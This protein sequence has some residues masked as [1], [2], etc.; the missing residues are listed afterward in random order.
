[1][2]ERQTPLPG[3]GIPQSAY[4]LVACVQRR[5][6]PLLAPTGLHWGLRRI[7]QQLWME[8]GVSQ[9]DL[10][11]AVRSSEASASNMLKHLVAG[12]WVERRGDAFDYRITRVFLTDKGRALR[13]AVAAECAKIDAELR[14]ELGPAEAT[15]LADQLDRTWHLLAEDAE[16][17]EADWPG[18]GLSQHPSPPGQL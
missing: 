13:D 8:D 16:A 15:Q 17:D 14:D 11:Q 18:L 7:L 5:L 2:G 1:M 9:V 3:A 12:G 6:A 10:A 4:A